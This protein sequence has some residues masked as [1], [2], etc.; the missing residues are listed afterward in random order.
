[1]LSLIVAA[2]V[3]A[4]PIIWRFDNLQ[5]IG[6]LA[7]QVEGTPALTDT[8]AGKAVRFDGKDDAFF[9][10]WH[11]LTGAKTFTIE[12]IFRPDGG[13]FEQR[14]LHLAHEPQDARQA[15]RILFEIRVEGGEWYLDAFAT[16]PGYKHTLI[17]P[18]KRYPV[19]RWYHVAQTF[20]GGTYRAYVNGVLQGEAPL[21]YTPQGPGRASVGMR[22]NRVNYF[23]GA[24]YEARFTPQALTPDEFHPLP[25]RLRQ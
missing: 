21:A 11:P 18:E 8:P 6:G 9:I 19:G 16:G 4:L 12:A 3:A 24:I 23:K 7:A 20:D 22:V 14:W 10:G 2:Q 25:D 17:F 1:M 15:A 13:A 5:R